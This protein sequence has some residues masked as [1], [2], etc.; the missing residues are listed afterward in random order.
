MSDLPA[1]AIRAAISLRGPISFAEFMDIALY[2]P[3][4]FYERPPVGEAGHF[5]TSPH[6]HP[7]FAELLA[8]G[9]RDL[10]EAMGA[11]DPL[12]ILELGAGDGTLAS[13]LLEALPGVPVDYVAVERSPGARASLA[14][15]PVRVLERVEDA[16]AGLQ[17]AV[18]A[19]ELLDNLP[20]HRVR[21][22]GR[23]GEGPVEVLVDAEGDRFVE[24]ETP[25][26]PELAA[27]AGS[28]RP[29][30]EAAVSPGARELVR[31]LAGQLERGYALLIDYGDA[32][33]QPA[34]PVHGYS[35]HRLVAEVLE[36][37]GA[38]DITAA[39]D[40]A[41]LVETAAGHGLEAHGPATQRDVLLALGYGD[42]A[43]AQRS[44][45]AA[46]LGEGRGAEAVRL[47]AARSRASLLVE[48][49][50]LG[51]LRWLLLATPGLPAPA[52]LAPAPD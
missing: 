18:L 47:W 50:G 1:Q 13:G 36:H 4:G 21:G 19:N 32:S 28:L 27:A 22:S 25:C 5:V 33:G 23:A 3:G 34:G 46:H 2:G 16:G 51:A 31:R 14:A 29:G 30:Q 17:G 20:F 44:T 52:W 38:S 39:V 40:F 45:Q 12:R 49:S 48:G 15:L 7:V 42:W 9:I 43:T 10:W 8:R 35:R 26:P 11:P 6:V 24:V 37:P 41:A